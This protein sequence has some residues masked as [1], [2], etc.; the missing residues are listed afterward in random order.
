MTKGEKPCCAAAAAAKL[1]Y[2]VVGGHRIAI[3]EL[4]TIV[5]RAREAEGQGEAAVRAVLLKQAK[6]FNYVPTPAEKEY[7][8]A[9][10]DEFKRRKK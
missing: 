5:A 3:A 8:D 2:I 10:F 1:Q 6:V 4:E 9:L 7:E